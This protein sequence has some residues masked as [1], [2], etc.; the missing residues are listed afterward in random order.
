MVSVPN[1]CGR[2]LVTM[3][4]SVTWYPLRAGL[5]ASVDAASL[6]QLRSSSSFMPAHPE[7]RVAVPGQITLVP[8]PG[9]IVVTRQP[10]NHGK[11]QGLAEARR[12]GAVP[13]IVLTGLVLVPGD[14]LQHFKWRG[15]VLRVS[16][17]VRDGRPVGDHAA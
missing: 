14:G 10:S 13:V 8:G 9:R 15:S 6:T 11:S 5:A 1:G 12:F 17:D 16:V 7:S 2:S 4:V 3:R